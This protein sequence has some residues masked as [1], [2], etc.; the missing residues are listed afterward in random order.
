MTESSVFEQV[1]TVAGVVCLLILVGGQLLGQP[2]LISY[3]ETESMSPTMEPGDGFVP[4]PA[5]IAGPVEEGD[6]VVFEAKELHGGGLTTHRVVGETDRGYIT[7]GDGNPFADQA[8]EEPPVRSPQIVA[9]ALELNGGIVVIPSFGT[10]VEAIQSV[11]ETVRQQVD[12]LVGTQSAVGQ[13]EFGV[14]IF[15]VTLGW[16]V[17]GSEDDDRPASRDRSRETGLD[18]HLIVVGCSLVVVLTATAAMAVPAGTHEYGVVSASFESDRPT[19]IPQ[20]ES[21]AV[22]YPVDNSGLIPIVSYVEP[23]SDGVTVQSQRIVVQPRNRHDVTVTLTAPD[24]TGYYRRYV[25]EHRYLAVLPPAVLDALHT[26]HPWAP[27]VTIDLLIGGSI[28]FG[29]RTLTHSGRLRDRSRD[30]NGFRTGL[31]RLLPTED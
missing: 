7:Q 22:S 17:I 16:Y 1:L 23:T 19:V 12:S 6:V 21:Q 4:V 14:S 30:E 10:G 5:Q 26:A 24:E 11:L 28:Y 18:T 13:R 8:N 25:S 3:V 20:G 15:V 29:G 2:V 31:Q 27:I 9:K